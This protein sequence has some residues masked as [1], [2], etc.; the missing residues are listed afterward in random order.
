V[1]GR[2]VGVLLLAA[3]LGGCG[4]GQGVKARA[5]PSPSVSASA[6]VSEATWVAYWA[7][8]GVSPAP[9]RDVA[10]YVRRPI[11]T[12]LN[13]TSGAISDAQ[14]NLWA[15]ALFRSSSIEEW[16]GEHLLDGVFTGST[17]PTG[18]PNPSLDIYGGVVRVIQKYKS[19]GAS[20]I[21]GTNPQIRQ[22]AVYT[23]SAADRA[24][25]PAP[26]VLTPF[27][28]VYSAV[29]PTDAVVQFPD[30]ANKDL[31]GL[32]AGQTSTTVVSGSLKTDPVLGDLWYQ[33]S[34]FECDRVLEVSSFCR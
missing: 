18:D 30:G 13:R 28:I 20:Q 33:T 5:T 25:V 8:L 24:R 32:R 23:T 11:P 12:A 9:P 16:A 7:K 10:D 1:K 19:Q 15:K 4:S 6:G 29:G 14:A 3:L 34:V 27:V 26:K 21:S 22:V 31:G 2:T 17:N